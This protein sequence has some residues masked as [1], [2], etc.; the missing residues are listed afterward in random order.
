MKK[1]VFGLFLFSTALFAQKTDKNWIKIIALENEGKIKSANEIVEKIYKNAVSKKDEVQMIKCF[2]YQSKY[3][4][5]LEENAQ[6]KIINKLKETIAIVSIPSKAIL[7][8]V[9][10]KCLNDY[11]SRNEYTITRRTNTT[12]LSDD[13][14]TWTSNNFQSEINVAVQQTT[15]N[16]SILKKT[17]LSNYE[18]IFDY[19]SDEDFKNENLFHYI[20]NENIQFYKQRIHSWEV[21]KSSFT[22]YKKELLGKADDFTKLNFDFVTEQ[23]LLKALTFYQKLE[24]EYPTQSNQFDRIIFCKNYLLENNDD[25]VTAINAIQKVTKDAVLIQKIQLEK[26]K[27]LT[28]QAS[29]EILPENH[30]KAVATLDSIIKVENRSNAYK[31]ALLL[32]QNIVSKSI[33][34]QLQK[35]IYNDENTRAFVEYKNVNHLKVSYFKIDQ[36][37]LSYFQNNYNKRDE[38]VEEIV[39]NSQPS[40]SKS[41][42]LK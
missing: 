32:K 12:E 9:Y 2:F 16:E 15:E 18:P 13:F 7:N 25:F 40:I 21:H 39:K 4:Q 41:Y 24:I 10:A 36:K 20:L 27:I 17:P 33:T 30:I 22:F 31:S 29:K 14:L 23:N 26:A 42:D 28:Q 37:Q 11:L 1:I 6:T 34:I 3:M 38:L 8:L 5:V 35:Y 19:S